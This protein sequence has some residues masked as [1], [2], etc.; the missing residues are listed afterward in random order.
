MKYYYINPENGKCKEYQTTQSDKK[1]C[2]Q[3][4][5]ENES[6]GDGETWANNNIQNTQNFLTDNGLLVGFFLAIGIGF[7]FK[8]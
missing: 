2:F 7:V 5:T 8:R 3:Q 4:F 6:G 1:I